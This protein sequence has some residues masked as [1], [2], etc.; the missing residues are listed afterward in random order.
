MRV[1]VTGGTGFLGRHI[2]DRLVA[3]GHRCRCWHRPTS[4]REGFA[5]PQAIEWV[6]GQLN[7][8]AGTDA[9]VAN[10]QAVVHAAVHWGHDGGLLRFAESNFMGTL[11]LMDSARAAGAERFIF[12]ASCSMHEVILDDRVLDEAHPLWPTSHYGAYKAAVE[13]FVHSFGFG[14]GWGACSLRPTGIYGLHYPVQ[15]SR[16]FG[17]V[18]DVVN[19]RPIN[20]ARGGKEVHAAD[21]AEAVNL[22]LNARLDQIQGQAFNCCDMYIADQ[23][24]AVIARSLIGSGSQIAMLNKG[25]QHEIDTSK[26]RALGMQFG[27][28]Q[29]LERAVEQLIEAVK[30]QV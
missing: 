15:R 27:G 10:A 30:S 20:S 1:A 3:A 16:W 6:G 18:R 25:C 21:C 14:H 7:D 24:V 4:N 29:Q 12:I 19:A 8:P 22:L 26:I 23:D 17:L 11:R 13:K 5:V 28:K 9:L 2:V